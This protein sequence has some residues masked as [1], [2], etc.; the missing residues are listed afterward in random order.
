M[1]AARGDIMYK[2]IKRLMDIILSI[3]GIVICAIPM[4]IVAVIIK[5]DS[6]GPVFF[7]QARLGLHGKEFKN[8]EIQIDVRQC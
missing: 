3:I 6:P 5:L 7:R 1:L 2:N 4:L 8:P